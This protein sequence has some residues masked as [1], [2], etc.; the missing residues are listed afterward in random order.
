MEWGREKDVLGQYL[1]IC[2]AFIRDFCGSE[3]IIR[4]SVLKQDLLSGWQHLHV[5]LMI[6]HKIS[7]QEALT[8]EF[9]HDMELCP[10]K[11]KSTA[12]CTLTSG[13]GSISM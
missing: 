13:A 4:P 5:V 3:N 9:W 1:W 2:V 12:N 11:Y 6:I 7:T 10:T 8:S